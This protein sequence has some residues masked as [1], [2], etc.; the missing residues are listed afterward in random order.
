MRY[1][2]FFTMLLPGLLARPNAEISVESCCAI[3]GVTVPPTQ[4]H[5]G[6]SCE[7]AQKEGWGD[8]NLDKEA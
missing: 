2:L 3:C 5:C 8:L 4:I 6:P 7:Q 1:P